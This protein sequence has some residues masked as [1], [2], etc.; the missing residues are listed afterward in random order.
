MDVDAGSEDATFDEAMGRR[1]SRAVKDWTG[2]LVDV[3]GRNTLLCYRD[4]KAGTLDFSGAT[5]VAVDEMLAGYAVPFSEAFGKEALAPAARR[6]RAIRARAEENFEERGLRTLFA[7]WGTATWTNTKSTFVPCAPVLLCQAHLVPHGGAAED[8]EVSLPGEW[9]INPTLLHVLAS[10]F[11]V[12]TEAESLLELLDPEADPPDASLLFERLAKEAGRVG[13]FGIDPR[14]VLANFSYAKLPMVN[15]LLAAEDLLARN[16]LICAIAGDEQA[17]QALRERRADVSPSA[18]DFTPPADEYLVLDADSS[19]SYAINAVVAGADLVIDGP[20]GT[21]KSQTIANLIATLSARNKKVLFVAEKRAAIDAVLSRLEKVG[22]GDLVLD[23]H[24]GPGAKGKLAQAFAKALADAANARQ[25][26][27]AVEQEQLARRRD[28]LVRRTAALHEVRQPWGISVYDLQAAL[29]GV[30]AP[31]QSEQRFSRE[32]LAGLGADAFRQVQANLEQFVGMGGLMIEASDS[33]WLPALSAATI[34]TPDQAAA[35]MEA[36]T[37][38]TQYTLPRATARIEVA[39]TSVGLSRPETVADWARTLELLQRAS[40]CLERFEPTVFALDLVAVLEALAPATKGAFGRFWHRLFDGAC[41]AAGKKAVGCV[42]PATAPLKGAEMHRALVEAKELLVD[43]RSVCTDSGIPRLPGDLGGAEGTYGQLCTELGHLERALGQSELE[44]LGPEQLANRLRLFIA[45][46]TTLYKL[47]ELYRLTVALQG[48]GL[49]G[50]LAELRQRNLAVDQAIACLRF[51]WYSS[52]LEAVSLADPEIGTFD[53]PAYSRTV[54]EFRAADARHIETTPA[55]IRRAVAE[56]V[57][58]ARDAYPIE[59]QLVTHEAGK[60]R[61][62]VPVRLLFQQ[63]PHVLTALKPCWAMSPLVVAQVLP[64]EQCFDVVIFDEASQVTPESA[65]GALMRA[66]QAVV[67]GDPHQLPPTAFFASGSAVDD[68]EGEAETDEVTGS[69]TKDF[70]SVLDVM[71]ALLPPP[72]GTKRLNWHYRSRDERLIAFSN[73]QPQLYDWSLTTFPGA[74]AAEVITHQLVPFV[75]GRIDQEQSVADEVTAVV[76]AV[77]EH[78]HDRSH[79]SL[80]VITMGIKH[81]ERIEEAL[82]RA[83]QIDS[84]LDDYIDEVFYGT[85]KFF[86]KNLERVQGDERDAILISIGYGKSA[87]GRILYRFGPLNNAGGERRLNVAVT[88]A[89]SR[90]AVISSFSSPDMDPTRL[91]ADG[92]QMLR[93]YLRYAESGGTDIGERRR[94]RDPLNP[95]EADVLAQLSAAGLSLECQVGCSGYWIDFAAKHP[96]QPGRYVLAI[97]ADGVMYHSS[98]T[99]RD[100]DRLRQDH[101]ER[102]GWHFHRIWSSDWFH[103]RERE[104]SSTV[105]AFKEALRDLDAPRPSWPVTSTEATLEGYAASETKSRE[106]DPMP[107]QPDGR[108]IDQYYQRDLVKFIRWIN[109]DGQLRTAEEI[110]AIAIRELGYER[111]SAPRREVLGTAIAACKRATEKA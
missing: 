33:P 93:A 18:P 78:A 35:V 100:R 90:I 34:T 41:R 70:E 4:L 81:M 37:T 26:N 63:A 13:G 11:E 106:R 25:P 15:D 89:R 105:L 84:V 71:G 66:S 32:E 64:V 39:L 111:T 94:E 87:D 99:A 17:R 8:F 57:I 49:L 23:L 46:R 74:E 24:D 96:T 95:F 1:I 53:G 67:A 107:F 21:G 73:A 109:S 51:V 54:A 22:L 7:A 108:P 16:T 40:G 98:A 79:E 80:G 45:D 77:S 47:P 48:A 76:K 2:Q 31:V 12:R 104:V 88:R 20:P 10:D 60:K 19:Q 3:S 43:W 9:E 91:K 83:R 68:I 14:V 52:V 38:F 101:L 30:P 86:V 102:L 59:S 56:H 65:A 69:M 36:M 55:R 72:R 27:V 50:L 82:R 28:T 61:R 103:Q 29:I 110:I 44:K 75:P 6:G 85:E 58:A 92:A 42:M 62:H 97:E 5:A